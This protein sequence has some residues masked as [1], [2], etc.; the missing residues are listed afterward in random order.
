MR[1]PHHRSL[2]SGDASF[3]GLAH[4]PTVTAR[5]RLHFYLVATLLRS[6]AIEQVLKWR[7]TGVSERDH[8]T[9]AHNIENC[10]MDCP[11]DMRVLRIAGPQRSRAPGE[12]HVAGADIPKTVSEPLRNVAKTLLQ[13]MLTRCILTDSVPPRVIEVVVGGLPR[14]SCQVLT[15]GMAVRITRISTGVQPDECGC[16]RAPETLPQ[17]PRRNS[18]WLGAPSLHSANKHGY[19]VRRFVE[20]L[21]WPAPRKQVSVVSG[22]EGD[23]LEW[24]T[25]GDEEPSV[26]T[27]AR[28]M[29]R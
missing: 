26:R 2:C 16:R 24:I 9:R 12:N 11:T 21:C 28:T 27:S 3:K 8:Q 17:R 22:S 15:D 6:G 13:R 20:C 4:P 29:L 5:L 1:K 25:S 23:L 7:Y 10:L 18:P 14:Q 19:D